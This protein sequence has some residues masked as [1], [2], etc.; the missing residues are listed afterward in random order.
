M[1]FKMEI[2]DFFVFHLDTKIDTVRSTL[3]SLFFVEP[4]DLL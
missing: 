1:L 3:I 4:S 2:G